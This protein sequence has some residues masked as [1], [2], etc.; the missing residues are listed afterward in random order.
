MNQNHDERHEDMPLHPDTLPPE[1]PA[2]MEIPQKKKIHLPSGKLTIWILAIVGV[3]SFFVV[4]FLVNISGHSKSV[5]AFFEFLDVAEGMLEI[6][7]LGAAAIGGAIVKWKKK[8]K[9]QGEQKKLES[10]DD[11]SDLPEKK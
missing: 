2:A 9:I 7:P 8:K 3:I 6:I 4:C 5:D 10:L 11:F 1:E